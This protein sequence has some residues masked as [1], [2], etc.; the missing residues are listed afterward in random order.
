MESKKARALGLW[1]RLTPL[2][3]SI[4]AH[5]RMAFLYATH[6]LNNID[7]RFADFGTDVG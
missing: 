6:R 5:A 4:E 3:Y 1:D 7:F 2:L